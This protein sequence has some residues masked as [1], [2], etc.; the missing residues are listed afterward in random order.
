MESTLSFYYVSLGNQT[1]V[2]RLG[3]YLSIYAHKT[4]GKKEGIIDV[5]SKFKL[6]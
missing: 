1:Q 3:E 5:S 6:S 2:T 4:R